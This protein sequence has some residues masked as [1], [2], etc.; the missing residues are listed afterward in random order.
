MN[1]TVRETQMA[2]CYMAYMLRELMLLGVCTIP[3]Y[4]SLLIMCMHVCSHFQTKATD[5][6][7]WSIDAKELALMH[8]ERIYPP[9]FQIRAY[10]TR[11]VCTPILF[12]GTAEDIKVELLLK[13][14]NSGIMEYVDTSLPSNI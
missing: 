11:C 2:C 6:D 8:K 9:R 3:T 10:A 5:V 14:A 7:F 12:Q 13:P 4:S 1:L